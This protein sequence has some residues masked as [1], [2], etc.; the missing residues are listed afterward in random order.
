MKAFFNPR[1]V[2]VVGASRQEGK[3]GH[4]VLLNLL[5][6]GFPAGGIYP[7][8]PG[9][10]DILGVKTYP[11]IPSIPGKIDLAV[12]VIPAAQIHSALEACV[13]K[14]AGAAVVI[15]AGFKE[16]GGEGAA[17][18]RELKTRCRELGIRVLGPNCLG[19]ISTQGRL[20]AS[21]SPGMPPEGGVGFFS[22]SGALG[23]AILDWAVGEQIGLSKFISLGN[24]MD[25]SEVDA[26]QALS[27]D[28]DTRVILG[29]VEGIERGREFMAAALA[30]SCRKPLI[31][32]KAGTTSAGARAASSHTGALVGSDKA[33]EAAFRQ[34]GVFRVHSLQELFALAQSFSCQPLPSGP[35]LLVLT[36]AGGPG[37]IAADAVEKSRVKMAQLAEETVARL[38]EFLPST[39][40]LYNPVDVI[41]DARADRYQK[42]LEVLLPDP[43]VDGILV[44][45]TPQS[46]TEI[47][48]TA[49]L[50]GR[51]AASRKKPVLTSFMGEA[52]VAEARRI[53]RRHQVPDY[54][55]PEEAVRA[56]EAMDVYR[57]WRDSPR[58]E[59]AAFPVR[60]GQ[61]R[62]KIRSVRSQGRT[63]LGEAEAR[64]VAEAFGFRFPRTT[65][66]QTAEEAVAAAEDAGYPVVLKIV[67]PEILHKTDVGGVKIGLRNG[68]EV[69]GGFLEIIAR[70]GRLFPEASIQ[71][72]LVQ[73]MVTGGKEVILGMS[74]DPQFGPLIM[75]GLGGIYVEV[76]KDVAFRV[77][78]VG[79]GEAESMIREIRSFPLLQGARGESPSDL[80]ALTE[81]LQRLSQLAVEL[82]EIL[83][84]DINPLVVRP[85]GEGTVAI[86]VR[87]S[88]VQEEAP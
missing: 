13:R 56:F 59:P 36:N 60:S 14:G 5:R 78:P 38:R 9:S 69:R 66:A 34:S 39:A 17:L 40:A 12:L 76:L 46:M 28:P 44:L 32:Y 53:L 61:A 1:T 18:E 86:D 16:V 15:S 52:S 3:V 21:F 64:F 50:V 63:E 80:S 4:S 51:A 82:P 71:G 55:F 23:T 81:G 72:V 47:E 24:K 54:P 57:S 19:I 48:R 20:N 43:G 68:R 83:E 37:I 77:A 33:V 73:E 62:E 31:M 10:A 8:N 45:L 7:V 58:A 70:V 84:M 67:S 2:A 87:M 22:Q 85:A 49:E 11:D 79:P 75:F 42:A 65:I 26:V 6:G 29:Y 88:L 74:R 41:G 35:R 27:E 30:A 25:L